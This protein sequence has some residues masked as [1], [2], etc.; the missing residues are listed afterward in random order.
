MRRHRRRLG[1]RPAGAD[2]ARCPART[3]ARPRARSACSAHDIARDAPRRRRARRPALRAR[4][5][6]RPRRGAD[7]LAGAEHAADAHRA[8][9]AAAGWLRTGDVDA[10]AD[11]LIRRFNVK[12]GG[13]G[14]GGQEPVGRQPAEVHRRPRDRRR[15]EAADRLAAD[16]GR[17]R[18]RGGADPR[19]AAG[20]A[21]RRLRAC[22][23]SARSSTSCSRSATG[24]SSSPRAGSRRACRPREA[25]IEMIG[26][27]MSGL[28]DCA[29]DGDE[30]M[31]QA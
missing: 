20:A 25:T 24:W 27:W 26:E 4:G 8:P 31:L 15:S 30:R 12:A 18:R 21:R 11:A 17:R 10:L 3:R 23:W 14:V 16:L 29:K 22:W 6:A 13:P 28:W 19:R 9:S 7:A 2:G 1:Q 5:A